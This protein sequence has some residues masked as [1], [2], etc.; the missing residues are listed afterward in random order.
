MTTAAAY[1]TLLGT[2]WPVRGDTRLLRAALVVMAGSVLLAVTAHVKVPFWPVPMTMQTFAVLVIGMACGARLGAATVAV[3][4]LEGA[5]GLPVFAGGAGFAYLAGPTGGYLAGFV[6]AAALTGWLAERGF[7]RS[8]LRTMA[9]MLAGD[10]II[11]GLGVAWLATLIGAEKAIAAG[12]LP[13][14]AAEVFKIVLAAAVLPGAW[15]L[16][17]GRRRS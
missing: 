14:L 8:V 9:A 17:G 7:D 12:L 3:Y 6:L 2:M 10:V 1:P 4:L 15:R 13:F 11:L 5:L 16:L